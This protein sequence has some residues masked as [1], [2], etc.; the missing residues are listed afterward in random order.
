[1]AKLVVY[2]GFV[3]SLGGLTSERLLQ[4]VSNMLRTIEHMPGVGSN[5][6]PDSIRHAFGPNVLKALVSPYEIIYEYDRDANTVYVY[7]LIYC[8][9]VM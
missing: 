4:N 5:L 2:N 7:D 6:V 8:P 1:M 9:N 3:E